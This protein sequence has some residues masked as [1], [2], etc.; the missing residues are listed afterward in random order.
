MELPT[1]TMARWR[2]K[3]G[4]L[5]TPN[6]HECNSS[7]ACPKSY[8]LTIYKVHALGDYAHTIRFFGTTDSYTT[9]I[10]SQFQWL[11]T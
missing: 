7:G 4:K 1:E 6:S 11:L 3:E 5:K 2:Q 9:Q 10:V 8:N